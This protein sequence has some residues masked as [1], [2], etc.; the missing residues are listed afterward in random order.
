[1]K[2]KTKVMF[3]RKMV[4]GKECYIVESLTNIG[5]ISVSPQRFVRV[6]DVV[7]AEEVDYV[8][9][10]SRHEVLVKNS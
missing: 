3:V 1:M 6:G 7:S 10:R 2:K 9:E 4:M 8:C 5:L